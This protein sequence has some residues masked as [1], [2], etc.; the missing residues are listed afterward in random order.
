MQNYTKVF[1]HSFTHTCEFQRVVQS[2]SSLWCSWSSCCW[3]ASSPGDSSWSGPQWPLLWPL[4]SA[5][6]RLRLSRL[7]LSA[8]N[9]HWRTAVT[10]VWN[11][12]SIIPRPCYRAFLTF[13]PLSVTAV[14]VAIVIDHSV[15]TASSSV[16][17]KSLVWLPGTTRT[18]RH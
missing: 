5:V 6:P 4:S 15:S 2:C 7:R 1:V 9:C 18:V 13:V 11:T 12:V 8:S 14:T 3:A 16:D 10:C 17:M